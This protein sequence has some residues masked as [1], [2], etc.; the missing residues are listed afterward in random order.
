MTMETNLRLPHILLKTAYC[1]FLLLFT[2]GLVVLTVYSI[3]LTVSSADM[4]WAKMTMFSFWLTFTVAG[5]LPTA[6]ALATLY[7]LKRSGGKHWFYYLVFAV[8]LTSWA[9]GGVAVLI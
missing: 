9:A 2:A 4:V 6:S 7:Y 8:Y 5:V 1:V 3:N